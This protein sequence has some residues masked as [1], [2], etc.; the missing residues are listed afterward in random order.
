[1]NNKLQ[2]WIELNRVKLFYKICIILE[3]VISEILFI[4]ENSCISFRP[5][6]PAKFSENTDMQKKPTW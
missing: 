6:Y 4:I 2:N 1:M 3:F 5:K